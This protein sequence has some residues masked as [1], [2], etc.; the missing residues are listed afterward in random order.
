VHSRLRLADPAARRDAIDLF[1]ISFLSLYLEILLI[2][3]LAANVRLLA[4]FTNITLIS[5]FFGLSL[6]VL[7]VGRGSR[8]RVLPLRSWPLMLGLLMAC[9]WYF[10]RAEVRPDLK[11]QALFHV[12]GSIHEGWPVSVV[13]VLFYLLVVLTFVPL[14]R[15]LGQNIALFEPVVAYSVN[16]LGS[17]AGVLAFAVFSFLGASSL[18]WFVVLFATALA[19]R[20][21]SRS[22][23]PAVLAV[24]VGSVAVVTVLDPP[25]IRWSP[26]H[27]IRLE[28]VVR[29]SGV[30]RT[31]VGH[32]LFI[33]RDI[34]QFMVDLSDDSPL[35]RDDPHFRMWRTIYEAPYR[36]G[37]PSSVLVVGAGS[38]NDVAAALRA[39]V[40]HVD[41]VDID[42]EIL[43]AGRELHPERPYDDPRVDAHCEDARQFLRR[44]GRQYDAIVMGY[45]DSQTL[46]SRMSNVRLDSFI[47]TL[48]AFR[49][50]RDRLE[51]D[52]MLVCYF[53]ATEPW[54]V[55]R[56][57]DLVTE[58]F[59]HEPTL[60][61]SAVDLLVVL[62]VNR[63]GSPLPDWRPDR[64][65][66]LED[67]RPQLETV[68]LTTDRWPFLY[69]KEKG[70]PADY[71]ETLGILLVLSLAL[72]V[73]LAP[74][75]RPTGASMFFL[76]AGFLLLETLAITKL[77][78][79]YG[80]TWTVSSAV[81]V[82]FLS[83]VLG[84]N[85]VVLRTGPIRL[86]PVY[87][88]LLTAIAANALVPVSAFLELAAVPR[89]VLSTA[90]YCLPIFCAGIIFATLFR[91]SL[92]PVLAFGANTMGAVV[93]G[94]LEY[95]GMAVGFQGLY[96]IVIAVYLLSW[97]G[98]PMPWRKT[99]PAQ[100]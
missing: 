59:G 31:P 34:Y 71:L 35:L 63:D 55:S 86:G 43:A 98:W 25:S 87:A 3:W 52:G 49:E 12:I 21:P 4:Y 93:G 83:A 51:P 50:I 26:Y 38:G 85:L 62:A 37:S 15:R 13:I 11:G 14:G 82:G 29:V 9:V 64:L 84:A 7:M 19:L 75:Q 61:R 77:S 88:V 56:L 39:G 28:E 68:P 10:G 91:R 30:E 76:G 54:I 22:F 1:L 5:A 65:V 8:G 94:F 41:A 72:L 58:A 79:L 66:E 73:V 89:I 53:A 57:Y 18:V 16:V 81:I 78:L 48:E 47:Y 45:L 100:R 92:D 20:P 46:F 69:I 24:A 44:P 90:L 40:D 80:A 27:K 36:L 2:R 99:P 33:N 70:V 95:L 67:V 17:I 23:R 60:Y 6:G 97:P 32:Q 42:R 74:G 96:W